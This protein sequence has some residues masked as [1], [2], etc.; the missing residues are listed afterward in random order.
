MSY[1][2]PPGGPGGYGPPGPPRP[3]GPPQG[4]PPGGPPGPPPGGPRGPHGPQGPHG[5]H[6][7][8]GPQGPHG[9]S[10]PQGPHGPR[11]P[12]GPNG[13]QGPSG[14]PPKKS[15]AKWILGGCGCGCLLVVI[16]LVVFLVLPMLGIMRSPFI[17]GSSSSSAPSSSEGWEPEEETTAYGE[18]FTFEQLDFPAVAQPD[19]SRYNCHAFSAA[20]ADLG[21]RGYEHSTNCNWR[22]PEKA[23]REWEHGDE[24]R[25]ISIHV[26]APSASVADIYNI[27]LDTNTGRIPAGTPLYEIPVGEHGYAFFEEQTHGLDMEVVFTDGTEIVKITLSGHAWDLE[28]DRSGYTRATQEELIAEMAE[29]IDAIHS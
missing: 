25:R 10:G 17:G 11:G 9:P 23:I 12:H 18:G 21:P 28:G 3:P 7:P 2:Q 27:G 15:G 20:F 13:P 8:S 6:G 26:N 19:G 29:I 5:P 22:S 16:L 24:V 4:G 14:R 1:P